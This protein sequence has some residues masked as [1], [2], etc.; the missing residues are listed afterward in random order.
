MNTRIHYLYRDADNYKVQNECVI[1]G[2]MTEEQEQRI[3]ACLDEK[4]YFV[5]SGAVTAAVTPI[6]SENSIRKRTRTIR[7]S[8]GSASRRPGRSLHSKSPPK[9]WS[10]ASKRRVRAGSL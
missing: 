6:I 3:I 7:G 10:S 2:E 5:P 1:L 4:E 9:S 8:S